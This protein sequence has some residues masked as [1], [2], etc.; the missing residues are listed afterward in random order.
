MYVLWQR[1]RDL[2]VLDELHSV[3]KEIQNKRSDEQILKKEPEKP[4]KAEKEIKRG[5]WDEESDSEES[6]DS[7]SEEEDEEPGLRSIEP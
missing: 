4:V 1:D 2:Q 7:E 5:R 3:V 6:S